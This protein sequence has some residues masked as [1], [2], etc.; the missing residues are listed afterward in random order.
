M[1]III[2][3]SKLVNL[4]KQRYGVD[5]SGRVQKITD[6]SELPNRFRWFSKKFFDSYLNRIPGEIM[7]FYL[8]NDGNKQ[9][10]YH[11]SNIPQEDLDDMIIDEDM[12]DERGRIVSVE[13]FKKSNNIPNI[14]ISL[15]DI[16]DM[17]INQ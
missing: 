7:P 11:F 5:F 17:Y 4:F 9:Y 3:E 14:G 2:T 16:F 12:V 6:H 15:P 8:I 13:D 10:L 1:K